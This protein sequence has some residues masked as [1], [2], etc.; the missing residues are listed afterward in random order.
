MKQYV[1]PRSVGVVLSK[2]LYELL[3]L[4]DEAIGCVAPRCLKRFGRL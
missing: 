3:A 1:S 2:A 4:S